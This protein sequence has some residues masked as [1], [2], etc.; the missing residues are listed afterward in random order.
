MKKYFKKFLVPFFSIILVFVLSFSCSAA[1]VETVPFLDKFRIG[2]TEIY[3][4]TVGSDYTR[5]V[6]NSENDIRSDVH[7]TDSTSL[8]KYLD[9][10]L[11]RFT[12]YDYNDDGSSS[13]S[14]LLHDEF[15]TFSLNFSVDGIFSEDALAPDGSPLYLSSARVYI[16]NPDYKNSLWNLKNH[17]YAGSVDFISI[18]GFKS[19]FI[20]N[21]SYHNKGVDIDRLEFFIIFKSDYSL[22]LDYNLQTFG[23]YAYDYYK[24]SYSS[25]PSDV[26]KYDN[27]DD[28]IG[29][30]IGGYVDEESEVLDGTLQGRDELTS[31]FNNFGDSVSQFV[32]PVAAITDAVSYFVD[33]SVLVPILNISLTCGCFFILFGVAGSFVSHSKKSEGD[34]HRQL[35][36]KNRQEYYKAR[37]AYYN[38][39][40]R[41]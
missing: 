17:Y 13:V 38:S 40:R 29:S 21:V 15:I 12:C 32:T 5:S 3:G 36:A 2:I 41:R 20:A 1:S 37:T 39:I 24:G 9:F 10:W 11:T 33:G 26:P 34:Y 8:N 35:S 31:F 23:N 14:S 30:D 6:S 7:A 28:S 16:I 4:W 27:P 25:A 19:D 22:V 18:N